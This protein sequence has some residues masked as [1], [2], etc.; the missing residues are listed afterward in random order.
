MD[1]TWI[2]KE[3]PNVSLIEE[4]CKTLNISSPLASILLQRGIDSYSKAAAYFNPEIDLLHDPFLM[5]GMEKAVK[6]LLEAIK[7]NEQILFYGDYDVDGTTSVALMV[8]FLSD[9]YNNIEYYI[10]DR[11]N[12]GYGISNA[13]ID[14]A[15]EHNIDLIVSLDCGIRA[16][17][18]VTKAKENNIDFI[19]CDHHNPGEVL[20]PAV[21]ILD[22]KQEDCNYP[23]KELS[24]CG[25]GFKLLQAYCINNSVPIE[26]LYNYLDL[27]AI[28]VAADI[29]PLTGENRILA[30]HGLQKLNDKPRQ[31]IS[32][33]MK[34]A[35]LKLPID[36]NTVVFGLAPRINAAGRISH[37]Y[38]AVTLLLS[39]NE[40]EANRV[41]GEIDNNNV[42]RREYDTDV[43]SEALEML[44]SEPDD[45]N[46]TVLFKP[47]WHKGII[48][49]VA[50]RCIE[51]HY[52]PTIILTESKGR[53]TG[54]ARSVKGFD[55][56]NALNECSEYLEQFGGHKYAAGLTMQKENLPLFKEKFENT[57]S[58]RIT[59]DLLVPKITIDQQI[60]LSEIS[61]NFI[62]VI[63]RMEPFG[64]ENMTPVFKT[65]DV[66]A[67]GAR[68]LKDKHLKMNVV[69][70]NTGIVFDAI[71]FGLSA[72][73]DKILKNPVVSV[74]YTIGFNDFRGKRSV[75]LYLK[76]IMFEQ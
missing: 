19:I 58:E 36:I 28:S 62:N 44:E 39:K 29:V 63:N 6:R 66:F 18:T 52:R 20:P 50:S 27:V 2:Q 22:P 69:D 73:Y 70:Q 45:I 34:V 10:P 41:A 49:I 13:G 37:A 59:A 8:G 21:A 3:Q 24:G 17:E 68:V 33:L 61:T 4:L 43:T 11:Y 1:Y 64:P 67:K 74:A 51:V 31:G 14:W 35:A 65:T 23:Y 54:S 76:D 47:H 46:T 71:G 55:I 53:I 38:G 5:K 12:E 40:D 30:Y 57:V 7:K 60:S 15:I 26:E 72:Y 42:I 32:A 48:G 16:V 75:Q 9:F 25:V 56:Y